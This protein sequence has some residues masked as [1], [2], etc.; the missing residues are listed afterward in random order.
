MTSAPGSVRVSELLSELL[1][2]LV[3]E[4]MVLPI[5]MVL[6]RLI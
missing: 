4:V 2:G 1:I 3:W 6:A 5:P